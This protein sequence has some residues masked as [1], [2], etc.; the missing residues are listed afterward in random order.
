[1]RAGSEREAIYKR[2]TGWAGLGWVNSIPQPGPG[3]VPVWPGQWRPFLAGDD[4]ASN[5]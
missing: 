2:L 5:P 4:Q 3:S 1:M